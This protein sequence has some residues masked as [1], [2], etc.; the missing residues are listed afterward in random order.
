MNRIFCP[1]LNSYT[2]NQSG[3]PLRILVKGQY[4]SDNMCISEV[5]IVNSVTKNIE[6]N[7]HSVC[8]RF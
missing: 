8:R 6:F 1:G 2:T 3:N 5:N 7:E 4:K